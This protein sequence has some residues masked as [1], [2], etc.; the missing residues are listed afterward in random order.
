MGRSITPRARGRSRNVSAGF[1]TMGSGWSRRRLL[2]ILTTAI[3][4]TVLLVV[5]LLHAAVLAI[6]GTGKDDQSATGTW[7]S[8]PTRSQNPRGIVYRDEIAATPMLEVDEEAMF[9]ADPSG[10][11]P[12]G[13]E[14]PTGHSPGPEQIQ[15]GFP[16]TPEG[17]IG[18]LAQIDIAVL[19]AMD[20]SKAR[21]VYVSWALPGGIGADRWYLTQGVAAFLTAASMGEALE[22]DSWVEVEPAA[23]LVKGTDGADW[24]TACVLL[25]VTATYRQEAQIAVGHCERM[26]W[27]GGRWMI[28]PGRPPAPAPSTW[29]GTDEANR[30]GWRPWSTASP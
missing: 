10:E 22:A 25:K 26:Q 6:G 18:Q 19:Q 24:T 23:A 17:A 15:S 30:A 13:I 8:E 2:A 4:T 20:T 29:P 5:G 28:A 9:P 7:V 3:A 14:I 16:R 21:K 11:L 27:V 1:E 12:R